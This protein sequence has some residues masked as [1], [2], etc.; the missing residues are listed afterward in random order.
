MDDSLRVEQERRGLVPDI[1]KE[2]VA[3]SQR[4][5]DLIGSLESL[6]VSDSNR[7]CSWFRG[8]VSDDAI[9]VL[10]E[11]DHET[12]TYG[13][14][15]NNRARLGLFR[16]KIRDGEKDYN[17]RLA[18]ILVAHLMCCSAVGAYSVSALSVPA[19]VASLGTLIGAPLCG[20]GVCSYTVRNRATMEN[21]LDAIDYSVPGKDG[22]SD[23]R[24]PVA[25]NMD[26]ESVNCKLE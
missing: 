7:L 2:M 9:D 23:F 26:M 5:S 16:E 11:I 8:N 17:C 22:E 13:L 15:E 6:E 4:V 3:S 18:T 25:I 10:K 1:E 14:S 12:L 21:G 19:P 24:V 20:L